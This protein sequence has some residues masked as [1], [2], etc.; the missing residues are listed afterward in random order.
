MQDKLAME[1]K[2]LALEKARVEFEEKCQKNLM[3]KEEFCCICMVEPR[4]TA[5]FP[6]GHKYFCYSCIHD[7]VRNYPDRGCPSCRGL[8]LEIKKVY[9]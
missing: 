1:M 8:V 3:E 4:N 6:C 7:Y 9:G 5:T 2:A